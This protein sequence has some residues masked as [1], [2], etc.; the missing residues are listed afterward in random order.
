M[1]IP[2]TILTGFLG[3]GKTSLLNQLIANHPEKKFAI[4]ENEFGEVPIDGDLVIGAS[5]AI[6]NWPMA[7][8]VAPS[9]A[10]WSK[11]WKSYLTQGKFST[12]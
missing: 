6:L 10:N 5:D 3:A 8:F 11:P 9:M 7:V 4:I 12:I 1:P 2:V